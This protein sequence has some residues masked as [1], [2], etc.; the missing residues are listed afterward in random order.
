[1]HRVPLCAVLLMGYRQV[2]IT[3]EHLGATIVRCRDACRAG[4]N[5]RRRAGVDDVTI[6]L[7]IGA[8]LRKAIYDAAAADK[9]SM[10]STSELCSQSTRVATL[11]ADQ[12][13]TAIIGCPYASSFIS[14]EVPVRARLHGH[15]RGHKSRRGPPTPPTGSDSGKSS[16]AMVRIISSVG[17]S[18]QMSKSCSGG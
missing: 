13:R 6:T 9:R 2:E 7:R 10:N 18:R 12:A 4:K 17:A 5:S 1:M 14:A 15:G 8:A 3:T 16:F 11:S